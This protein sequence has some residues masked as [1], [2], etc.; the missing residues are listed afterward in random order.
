MS[1]WWMRARIFISVCGSSLRRGGIFIGQ[2]LATQANR[3]GTLG[4][5][6][7]AKTTPDIYVIGA[8]G[9]LDYMGGADSIVS[10][11]SDDI[12]KAE[13]YVQEAILAVANG[14][15]VPHPITRPYSCNVK[16]AD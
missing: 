4:H 3:E 13:P 1:M 16:H 7:D 9:M 6:Y 5:L 2:I 15:P 11:D 10:T 14:K 12:K 8:D